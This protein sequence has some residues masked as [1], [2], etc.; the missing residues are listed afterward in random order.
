MIDDDDH[1]LTAHFDQRDKE[2]D[3]ISAL[4]DQDNDLLT[5]H[6]EDMETKTLCRLCTKVFGRGTNLQK[7][8]LKHQKGY[9]CQHCKK[10]HDSQKDLD[11]HIERQHT[12]RVLGNY[13]TLCL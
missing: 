10:P 4:V 11:I 7:H 8:T 6:M 12:K 3:N 5:E 1:W 9:D 2:Q 13:Y